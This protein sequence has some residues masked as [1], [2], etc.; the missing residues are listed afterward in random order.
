MHGLHGLHG[1]HSLHGLWTSTTYT[2][3][4][5]SIPTSLPWTSANGHGRLPDSHA[6]ATPASFLPPATPHGAN[7]LTHYKALATG[8]WRLRLDRDRDHDRSCDCNCDYKLRSRLRGTRT[9]TMRTRTKSQPRRR[10]QTRTHM[11]RNPRPATY[12]RIGRCFAWLL[13]GP[14]GS[15]H[16]PQPKDVTLPGP[17]TA[18]WSRSEHRFGSA[19]TVKLPGGPFSGET[20]ACNHAFVG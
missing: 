10:N 15:D 20:P 3:R 2:D 6:L 14:L 12:A 8:E 17:A 5:W 11:Y 1:L 19:M 13:T 16:D 18:R 7:L 9:R 4:A